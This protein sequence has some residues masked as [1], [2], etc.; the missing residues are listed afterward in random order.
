MNYR[1]G[2]F[3]YLSLPELQNET[4]D[5]AT[6]GFYGVQDQRAALQW[7]RDNIANFGGNPDDVYIHSLLPPPQKAKRT[8]YRR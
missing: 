4:A 2:T 3:G 6:T 7:V 1:L 8:I 5:F